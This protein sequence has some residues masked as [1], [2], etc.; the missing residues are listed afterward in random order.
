MV[1]SQ[2]GV[3][4][5]AREEERDRRLRH[6]ISQLMEVGSLCLLAIFVFQ[7]LPIVIES[8]PMQPLWQGQFV[9]VLLNQSVLAFLGFVLLHLAVLLHPN[10][11]LLRTWLKQ[12]RH[13]AV[14]ATV[15]YLL[16]IPLQL[17][18]SLQEF[19]AE[20]RLQQLHAAQTTRLIEMREWFLQAKTTTDIDQRLL[21]ASEPRLTPEQLKMTLPQLQEQLQKETLQRQGMLKPL[22]E[23]KPG[24]LSPLM[25]LLKRVGSSLGWSLA[26]SAGA[27]PW[28]TK[29]T[30]FDRLQRR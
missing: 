4:E 28:G 18:S 8:K 17:S 3:G 5:S 1:H 6:R 19:R 25:L 27:V 15:A 30:L 21:A 16:L 23:E 22:D 7:L 26:F 12:V 14:L 20:R 13:L 29:T 11:P 2:T 24:G 10:K 9:E